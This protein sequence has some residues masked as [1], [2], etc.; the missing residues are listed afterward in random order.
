MF[1]PISLL[2]IALLLGA[3]CAM[4]PRW[5]ANGPGPEPAA[6]PPPPPPQESAPAHGYAP[7]GLGMESAGLTVGGGITVPSDSALDPGVSLDLDLYGRP[8]RNLDLALRAQISS[9]TVGDGFANGRYEGDLWAF[10][11]MVGVRGVLPLSSWVEVYAG[12]FAGWRFNDGNL[13]FS[14]FAV[15]MSRDVRVRISDNYTLQGVVGLQT[16]LFPGGSLGLEIGAE[17]HRADIDIT[18]RDVFTGNIISGAGLHVD[19][20]NLD[21]VIVRIFGGFEF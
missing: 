5:Y 1:K 3:G 10:K 18:E 12:G 13:D 17:Y 9:V 21:Q 8:V 20:A 4:P 15:A 6:P 19:N 7:Y 16:Y 11:P 14:N 2:M